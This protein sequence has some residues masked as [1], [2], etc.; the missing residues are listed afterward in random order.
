MWL[1]WTGGEIS[2]PSP[3]PSEEVNRVLH[4]EEFKDIFISGSSRAWENTMQVFASLTSDI[5]NVQIFSLPDLPQRIRNQLTELSQA[6]ASE[7]DLYEIADAVAEWLAN[8]SD[9]EQAVLATY[10]QELPARSARIL[11]SAFADGEVHLKGE[12]LLW[13]IASFLDSEDERL[14]QAAAVCLLECGSALG[15]RALLER[16]IEAESI[17]HAQLIQGIIEMLASK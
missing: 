9:S 8:A 11:L 2:V 16:M 15:G 10:L 17:P 5:P 7:D 4:E 1:L 13:T 12:Q 6:S 14:A 3:F